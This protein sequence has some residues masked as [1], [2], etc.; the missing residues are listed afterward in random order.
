MTNHSIL[1]PDQLGSHTVCAS[2]LAE[3]HV[4]S[5]AS[6]QRLSLKCWT[7]LNTSWH[8]IPDVCYPLLQMWCYDKFKGFLNQRV[9]VTNVFMEPVA[10]WP[11]RIKDNTDSQESSETH[12]YSIYI[13]RFRSKFLKM[14][15]AIT[16]HGWFGH[17]PCSTLRRAAG[18]EPERF[19]RLLEGGS[20]VVTVC[21]TDVGLRSLFQFWSGF[22]CLPAEWF[23]KAEVQAVIFLLAQNF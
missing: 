14:Y 6:G 9:Q 22:I 5:S 19:G 11:V 13:L 3:Y 8:V 1:T 18:K 10:W 7:V 17:S 2:F 20:S 23:G 15:C 21:C 12:Q 4:F 16:G